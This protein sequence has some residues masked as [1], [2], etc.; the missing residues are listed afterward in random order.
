MWNISGF[1]DEIAAD[2][3]AQSAT[4]IELGQRFIDFRSAW[5]T[6]VLELDDEQLQQVANV[7]S[8]GEIAVSCVAS[9]IGKS[10]I[11]DDFELVELQLRRAIEIALIFGTPLIRIFSFYLREGSAPAGSR[12][13]VVGRMRRLTDI[14]ERNGIVLLHENETGTYGDTPDRCL[15]LLSAVDSSALRATLDPGN[16]VLAGARPFD[17]GYLTLETFI[18]HVQIK[19]VDAA[20]GT[21]VLAG[22]GSGQI[23]LILGAL[24]RSGYN[25]FLALEPHL[26]EA[27][28]AGGFSGPDLYAK[29]RSALVGLVE[30]EGVEFA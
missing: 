26:V 15:D 14:A 24:A 5:D 29:A 12:E 22:T 19:D 1:A 16:F 3:A 13:E 18:D 27:G 4:L 8:S 6:N 28:A 25:G 2:P 23:P 7:F 9:P 20:T 11:D 17:D 10:F 21:T 30:H